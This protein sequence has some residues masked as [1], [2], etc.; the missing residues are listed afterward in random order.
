MNYRRA[1]LRPRRRNSYT[2]G[3][4]ERFN[5]VLFPGGSEELEVYRWTPGRA[6]NAYRYESPPRR[7]A[8]CLTVYDRPLD[9]FVII[10]AP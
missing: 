8:L 5:A 7:A 3:D 2:D 9:R 6:K 4:F 1:F 10:T